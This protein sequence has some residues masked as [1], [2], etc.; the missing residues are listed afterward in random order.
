MN[1]INHILGN[2]LEMY[3]RRP[4]PS[5]PGRPRPPGPAR[6]APGPGPLG[7][8]AAPAAEGPGQL[9]AAVVLLVA[10]APAAAPDV[11]GLVPPGAGPPPLPASWRLGAALARR[12][13]G[14]GRGAAGHGRGRRGAPAL[15]LPRRGWGGKGPG[16]AELPAVE[17]ALV[18]PARAPRLG[19]HGAAR[20]G[21]L[22]REARHRRDDVADPI[23]GVGREPRRVA[24][25]GLRQDVQAPQ[26]AGVDPRRAAD[27]AEAALVRGVASEGEVLQGGSD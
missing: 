3:L 23:P 21:E 4:A 13:R 6:A 2:L 19:G 8:R 17:L 16:G 7:R 18:E 14:S 9:L 11:A 10:L 27:V 20:F 12:G 24:V 22:P 26:Q 15:R 25:E 5:A 1:L